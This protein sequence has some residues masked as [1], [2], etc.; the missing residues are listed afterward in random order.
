ME[1]PAE[2]LD[3]LVKLASLGTAGICIVG[4]FYTGLI[5]KSLPN[6]VSDAKLTAVRMYKNMC[7]VIAIICSISGGLNAFFNMG[8][9]QDAK[10]ETVEIEN[11]YSRQA[12][13]LMM[14][15]DEIGKDLLELNRI[16]EDQP[17]TSSEASRV[18]NRISTNINSMVFRPATKKNQK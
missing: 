4:I 18:L 13:S 12:D 11:R 2:T 10:Q 14:S 6:N 8:K 17:G 7:I 1:A 9:I 5:V 3:L 16:L 15:K